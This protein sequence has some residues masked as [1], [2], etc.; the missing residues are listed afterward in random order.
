[1]KLNT[2]FGRNS[3]NDSSIR[4]FSHQRNEVMGWGLGGGPCAPELMT[5]G[6]A[7][8]RA[9]S[10]RPQDSGEAMAGVQPLDRGLQRGCAVCRESVCCRQRPGVQLVWEANQTPG[11]GTPPHRGAQSSTLTGAWGFTPQANADQ[12]MQVRVTYF[13]SMALAKPRQSRVGSWCVPPEG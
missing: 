12:S 7:S 10:R 11:L 9:R 1:M 4:Y 5:L 2:W 8:E 6:W 13:R 3:Y